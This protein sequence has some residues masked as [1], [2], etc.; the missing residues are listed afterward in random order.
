MKKNLIILS[1]LMFFISG[2][3]LTNTTEPFVKKI[4]LALTHTI[5]EGILNCPGSEVMGHNTLTIDDDFLYLYDSK[6][7]F[8]F[9]ALDLK[10]LKLEGFGSWGK[11]PGEVSMGL[12]VIMSQTKEN[13]FIYLPMEMRVLVFKKEDLKLL[14]DMKLSKFQMFSAFYM[15]ESQ[16]GIYID[17]GLATKVNNFAQAYQFDPAKNILKET[18]TNYGEYNKYTQ[19]IAF[20]DNPML[21]KGPIHKDS[22][23]N[24]YLANYYSS[25]IMGFTKEGRSIFFG[26]DPR[27]IQIPKTEIKKMGE[28]VAGDPERCTQS[29]LSLT[30]DEKNL[31]ALFSGEEITTEK[32]LAYRMGKGKVE[33]HLGEG[34]IVDVFN[35]KDGKYQY[36][37]ELPVLATGIA[38]KGNSLYV[39]TIDG[40]PRLLIFKTGNK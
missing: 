20:K 5:G 29:Y 31:Y 16:L 6:G 28:I 32:V 23:G 8:P 27:S 37:F 11:G 9:Y 10:T 25:L 18:S 30:S 17:M 14:H 38:V 4:D 39:T 3:G 26:F 19:L 2:N 35:K 1:I 15:I 12:P 7:K 40:E 36:S 13:L 33:L 34:R 22:E 21:K 24:I